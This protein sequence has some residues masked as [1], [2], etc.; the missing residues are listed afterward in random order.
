VAY[1]I[2]LV[3]GTLHR[4]APVRFTRAAEGP[5][6]PIRIEFER[7][8]HD[9]TGDKG[10]R[11]GITRW[12][13]EPAP[14]G[15]P[16]PP[17]CVRVVRDRLADS[18]PLFPSLE[19]PRIAQLVEPRAGQPLPASNEIVLRATNEA[20]GGSPTRL[21]LHFESAQGQVVARLTVARY[22]GISVPVQLHRAT[23]DTLTATRSQASLDLMFRRVNAI[24]SQAGVFFRPSPTIHSCVRVE[25]SRHDGTMDL[26]PAEPTRFDCGDLRTVMGSHPTPDALNVYL[27]RAFA[28][29]GGHV[30]GYTLTRMTGCTDIGL[31][32]GFVISDARSDEYCAHVLAHEIGHILGLPHF[33][34]GD[35]VDRHTREDLWAHGNLMY[36][37]TELT[38]DPGR[39]PARVHRTSPARIVVGYGS[40]RYG[41]AAGA[42]LLSR[43]RSVTGIEG[44]PQVELV[45][46]GVRRRS[47]AP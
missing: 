44:R 7:C 3:P 34:N 20:D 43:G 21:D 42:L 45:R 14:A 26:G 17:I 39:L 11:I 5:A 31:P 13:R 12:N 25:T 10:P 37:G 16:F 4:I 36:W 27:V 46:D 30:H 40:H 23:L 38:G 47:Y 19:G 33:Q 2:R 22:D 8:G 1:R 9:P 28:G 15:D 32:P 6:D 41:E 29:D 24:Y 35:R 18:A